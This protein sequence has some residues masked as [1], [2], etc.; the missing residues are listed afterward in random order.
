MEI[1]YDDPNILYYLP[2]ENV[3]SL[4]AFRVPETCYRR[5]LNENDAVKANRLWLFNHPG[6][7]FY[8]KRLA[9]FNPT[10]GIFTK[11]DDEMI[12]SAFQ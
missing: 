6:S 7:L 12:S 1:E 10:C 11:T 9:L 4:D 8:L 2:K 5:C 3:P